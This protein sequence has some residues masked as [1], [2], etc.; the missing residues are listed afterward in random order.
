MEDERK[1]S[2]RQVEVIAGVSAGFMTTLVSHPLDLIKVRLQLNQQSAK[3]PFGLL[4]LVVQDIHKSANQDYAKFLEQQKPQHASPLIKHI[5]GIYILRT[6]YRGV[7]ANLLGNIT[8]WSVYFALYAEFKSRLPDTNFTLNYFGSSALAGI[9]TSLLTNPI[10]VLKTRILGTPR[11]HENAYKSVI[12]GVLKIIQNEGISSFWRG[13][14]PS[15]FLVFQASLQFTFYDHLKRVLSRLDT[16][17]ASFL[18]PSEYI[19]CSTLSKAMSSMLMY[20]TQV[21]RSRLQAYNTSGDKQTISLVCRQIWLHES[22][23]R[24]FYKGMGTN[25]LRVLP[26]TCVTFLSYEIVKNELNRYNKDI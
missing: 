3:G 20:P 19:L 18:S 23:W 1:I 22:K 2:K 25:M 12:D 17:A 15:M 26:A 14:I 4:R 21:I 9:S 24:G 13:C 10:W 6:Y 16:S 5:K 11:N 8:A 7:G